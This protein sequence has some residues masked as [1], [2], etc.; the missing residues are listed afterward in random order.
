MSK[1]ALLALIGTLYTLGTASLVAGFWLN[2][3]AAYAFFALAGSCAAGIFILGFPLFA[4]MR[5]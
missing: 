4:Q 3:G 2:E 1:K 5:F